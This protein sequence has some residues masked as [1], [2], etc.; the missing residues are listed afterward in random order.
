MRQKQK[1][2]LEGLGEYSEH[3]AIWEFIEQ[4]TVIRNRKEVDISLEDMLINEEGTIVF[5]G[6]ITPKSTQIKRIS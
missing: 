5:E 4:I 6:E 2:F 1:Y 3:S